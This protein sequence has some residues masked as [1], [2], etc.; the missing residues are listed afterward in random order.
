MAEKSGE[1]AGRKSASEVE[2]FIKSKGLGICRGS[3]IPKLGRLKTG[4]LTLDHI[5]GGGWPSPGI[6]E[7]YGKEQ[8]FK[9]T[10]ALKT[11][12]VA[13]K[14][15]EDV[16]YFDTEEALEHNWVKK[17]FG[18]GGWDFRRISGNCLEEVGDAILEG[19]RQF[20]PKLIIVDSI[21]GLKSKE[22]L[23]GGVGDAHVAS[24]ARLLSQ[25]FLP[26]VVREFRPG[27][28]GEH[29]T[30]LLLNQVRSRIGGG[31]AWGPALITPGGWALKF[32]SR[33]R[34]E[35]SSGERLTRSSGLPKGRGIRD[36]DKRFSE[37]TI[38]VSVVAHLVKSKVSMAFQS[39]VFC[40]MIKEDGLYKVG[41][42]RA[43]E[44]LLFLGLLDG[45]IRQTGAWYEY[46]EKRLQ[47][48]D[49]MANYLYEEY[50]KT[51]ELPEG[52]QGEG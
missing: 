21:A 32:Y 1:E 17:V 9:T 14:A 42:T 22:V 15:G 5:L 41:D 39:A 38:G 37:S 35:L 47:G 10:V 20:S 6:V 50:L 13:A 43:G 2:E 24:E 44:E 12:Q 49:N 33:V 29:T 4:I 27:C 45:H 11:A 8:T 36:K 46:G 51:G 52:W 48:R 30:V 34:V 16:W 28:P 19:M 18:R 26:K 23:D 25:R 3:E 40:L 31:F 7:I